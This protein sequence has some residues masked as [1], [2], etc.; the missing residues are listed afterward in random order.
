[1]NP[2]ANMVPRSGGARAPQSTVAINLPRHWL[3]GVIGGLVGCALAAG[4][5]DLMLAWHTVTVPESS[6]LTNLIMRTAACDLELLP[7]Y[8]WVMA[9]DTNRATLTWQPYDR[10]AMLR[11]TM[12]PARTSGPAASVNAAL[13]DRVRQEFH[14]A[15]VWDEAPCYSAS[16]AG[17]GFELEQRTR[18]SPLF[19]RLA[20]LPHERG[21]LVVELTGPFEER[22]QDRHRWRSVMNS[23]QITPR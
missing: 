13:R 19:T 20:F 21:L 16:H 3:G 23:L 22:E 6:T 17:R 15:V 9:V 11:L 18:R 12:E 8:R 10:S 2:V 7:P 5:A 14:D 1:M 4:A